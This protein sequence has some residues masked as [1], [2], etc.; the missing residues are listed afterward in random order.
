LTPI[1][2]TD[3]QSQ[4]RFSTKKKSQAFTSVTVIREDCRTVPVSITLSGAAATIRLANTVLTANGLTV[5]VP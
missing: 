4:V 2:P 1:K 5:V 3:S